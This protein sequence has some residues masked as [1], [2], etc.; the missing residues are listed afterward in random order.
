MLVFHA[1]LFCQCFIACTIRSHPKDVRRWSDS[2]RVGLFLRLGINWIMPSRTRQGKNQITLARALS[3]LGI[4]SRSQAAELVKL[5]KVKV[6][7]KTARSPDVWIDLKKERIALDGNLLRSEG[8]IYL[9]FNKPVG[10]V[11]TRSDELG[12]KTVYDF[13]PKDLPWIFPIGRLDKDT[14]GLLLLTNDTRF[15]EQVTNPLEKVPK[16]YE[17]RLDKPLSQSD[18]RMLESPMRLDDG[19]ELKPAFVNTVSSDDLRCEITIHEGKNRQIK[20]MF[21]QLGYEVVTL[22]RLSIGAI[23]LGNLKEGEHRFLTIKEQ[24]SIT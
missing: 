17:V 8:K 21:E 22:K 23:E 14:S 13:L 20:R 11:T 24:A 3:K 1:E 15:G 19:T 5:G 16:K 9:A 7:G 12:R 6:D 18:I 2:L 4:A 10:V